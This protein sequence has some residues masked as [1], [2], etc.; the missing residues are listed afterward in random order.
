MA[1][2]AIPRTA[3]RNVVDPKLVD[4]AVELGVR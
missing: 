2:P 1:L 4:G 3:E